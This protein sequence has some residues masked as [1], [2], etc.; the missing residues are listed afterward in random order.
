[1]KKVLAL[2]MVLSMAV[3]CCSCGQSESNE[4]SVDTTGISKSEYNQLSIG[5]TYIE[6]GNIIGGA[7]D[8]IGTEKSG[9]SLIYTYKFN[10][11]RTG[12]AEL[13]FETDTLGQMKLISL[14][15]NDLS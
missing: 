13:K 12:Y 1:M 9:E 14:K 2:I 3:V 15:E 11:E 6:V 4:V 10:G 7:G 8:K 5:M